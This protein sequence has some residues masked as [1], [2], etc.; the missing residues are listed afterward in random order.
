MLASVYYSLTKC[1][2]SLEISDVLKS[3]VIEGL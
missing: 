2:I 3:E 1:T